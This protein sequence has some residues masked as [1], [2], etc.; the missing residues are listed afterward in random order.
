MR[1][2]LLFLVLS[3]YLSGCDREKKTQFS[4]FANCMINT[5]FFESNS[6]QFS[7]NSFTDPTSNQT[8]KRTRID[9]PGVDGAYLNL[10][11][12][13]ESTGTFNFTSQ[14]ITA[15][16][17]TDI[18]AN[19]YFSI[20]GLINITEYSTANQQTTLTG[21]FEIVAQSFISQQTITIT[22]GNFSIT[23]NL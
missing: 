14:G 2:I 23:K 17:Y 12:E 16:V 3:L 13:G 8:L 21:N 15:A 22:N 18:N 6:P 4:G 5:N 19:D 20:S 10:F 1:Y 7:V 11:F 9:L